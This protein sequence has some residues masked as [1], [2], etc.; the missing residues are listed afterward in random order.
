M[1]SAANNLLLSFLLGLSIFSPGPSARRSHVMSPAISPALTKSNEAL[2]PREADEQ[3]VVIKGAWVQEGPPSQ[4]VTAAYML[5]EN[6]GPAEIELLSASTDAAR[7]VE[8]H[9][10]ELE[11]RMMRMRRVDSIRIP[12][13]GSV[14]LKPGGYHLMVIGL[15]KVLKE[16]DEVSFALQF[17]GEIRKTM[18]APVKRRDSMTDGDKTSR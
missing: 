6:H 14:E 18:K 12:A 16:G 17:S 10:M 5:I 11:G 2:P 7:V 9:K 3:Q 15:K 1:M 4:A 8:L 13:G